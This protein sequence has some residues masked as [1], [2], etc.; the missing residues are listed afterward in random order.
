MEDIETIEQL[1]DK[2]VKQENIYK[3]YYSFT[4]FLIICL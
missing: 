4:I 2:P 1:Y 3:L